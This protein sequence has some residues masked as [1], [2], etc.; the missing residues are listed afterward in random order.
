MIPLWAGDL[1]PTVQVG[2]LAGLQAFRMVANMHN[3]Y[4]FCHPEV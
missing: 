3:G 4:R 1:E 2:K